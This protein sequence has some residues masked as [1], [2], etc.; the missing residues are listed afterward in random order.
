M[1][2]IVETARLV[3]AKDLRIEL[4]TKDVTIATALFA[5]LVVVIASLS[6]YIDRNRAQQIAPGVLWVAIAFAGMMAMNRGWEREA[7]G[8]AMRALLLSPAP[9]AGIY[10]GKLLSNLIFLGFVELIVVPLVGIFFHLDGGPMAWAQLTSVLFFGTLGF[11]AAGTLFGVM[12]VRLNAGGWMLSMV[13]FPLITPGLL[14]AVAASRAI[15]N[16]APTEEVIGWLR[17]LG[18]VDLVFLAFGLVL[19]DPLTAD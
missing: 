1:K 10:L 11:V 12:A 8:G 3:A 16:D 17:L 19:F 7:Q 6:F 15:F 13:V 9:R 2:A 5:V 4:R 14:G 18:A